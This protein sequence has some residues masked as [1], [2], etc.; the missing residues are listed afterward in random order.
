MSRR[1]GFPTAGVED[2]GNKSLKAMVQNRV[3]QTGLPVLG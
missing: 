3:A 1:S 2:P